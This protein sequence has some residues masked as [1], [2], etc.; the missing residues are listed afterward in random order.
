M[1]RSPCI[2][3]VRLDPSV[4]WMTLLLPSQQQKISA[5]HF[6]ELRVTNSCG[7]GTPK[8]GN[9]TTLTFLPSSSQWLENKAEGLIESAQ[10]WLSVF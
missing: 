3:L 6:R 2:T 9:K 1:L 5:L 10:L 7:S 4:A 8:V